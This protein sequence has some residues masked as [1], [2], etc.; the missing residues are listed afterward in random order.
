MTFYISKMITFKIFYNR[1]KSLTVLILILPVSSI[2]EVGSE[3]SD[4]GVGTAA[5]D[6]LRFQ[7]SCFKATRS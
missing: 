7:I 6:R 1:K 4:A 5:V 3:A 2:S